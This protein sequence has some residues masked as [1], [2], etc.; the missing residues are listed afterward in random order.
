MR[1]LL[2]FT[3]SVSYRHALPPQF[4]VCL[5]IKGTPHADGSPRN[6][7]VSSVPYLSSLRKTLIHMIRL[8]CIVKLMLT[9]SPSPQGIDGSL[10]RATGQP[11]RNLQERKASIEESYSA[12]ERCSR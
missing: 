9:T 10:G 5:N 8:P 7:L 6:R 12:L 11:T 1:M 4:G 3:E 2:V